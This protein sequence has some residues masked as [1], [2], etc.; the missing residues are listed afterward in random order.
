MFVLS[1]RRNDWEK[2]RSINLIDLPLS[3]QIAIRARR[4]ALPETGEAT[5]LCRHLGEVRQ[6]QA[7]DHC[8]WLPSVT[9][10]CAARFMADSEATTR[11]NS[12]PSEGG[13]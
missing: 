10:V 6:G 1:R 5:W 4:T 11:C 3:L 7:A 2:R 12:L 8:G 13:A 9:D